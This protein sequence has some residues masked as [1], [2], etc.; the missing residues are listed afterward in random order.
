MCQLCSIWSIIDTDKENGLLA[1]LSL[2]DLFNLAKSCEELNSLL[3]PRLTAVV[4]EWNDLKWVTGH[5]FANYFMDARSRVWKWADFTSGNIWFQYCWLLAGSLDYE[6]EIGNSETTYYERFHLQH[7][8]LSCP[9]Q[10]P[11]SYLL[12]RRRALLNKRNCRDF[13]SELESVKWVGKMNNSWV[14]DE[15]PAVWV[16]FSPNTVS[17]I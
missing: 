14:E 11:S 1:K 6:L 2:E 10:E 13:R 3:L 16:F 7:A 9:D 12:K 8:G 17:K 4:N 5:I 15:N